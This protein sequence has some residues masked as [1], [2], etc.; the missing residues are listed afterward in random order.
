MNPQVAVKEKV[1]LPEQ[2]TVLMDGNEMAAMAGAHINYHVMG[3][4]PITPSTDI[5]ENL[6]AMKADGE[7]DIV[8]I[9]GD[10]EHGAAGSCYGAAAAGGRVFNATSSQGLL[11]ALEQ[12]P[13]QSG[14][15]FP[16][17]LNVVCRS[18]S[19]PLDIRGDHSDIMF[20]LNT[21]WIILLAKDQQMVYDMNI[22]A[23]RLGEHPDV[24]LPVIVGFDGFFT[25]HQKRRVKH[26]TD[27][28]VVQDFI[29]PCHTPYNILDTKHP[30]TIGAYMNDP[31]Y[32][33]NKKQQ[34][35][36]MEIAYRIA[37][38]IIEEY[39][40]LSGRHYP[41]VDTYRMEDAE[42]A[43]FILNSAFD[44]AKEAVDILRKEG[45]KVG[46]VTSYMIRP[47]PQNEIQ[48]TFRNAAAICVGDRQES[49]GGWGGNMTIEIKAALKDDPQNHS[50]V[51][52]RIYGLGGK[53]FF[54]G[55]AIQMLNEA[56]ET[57]KSKRVSSKMEYIGATPG[58]P[59]NLPK[60]VTLPLTAQDADPGIIRVEKDEK[61]GKM[62]V[63]GINPRELT[64]MPKR[65]APGHGACPGC[66]IF[67]ALNAFLR[68]ISGY[69]V[70]LFHTGCGMITTTP[71]PCTS[72][73][74]TYIHNLFQNGA[75][76]LAGTVEMYHERKR[77][78]EIPQDEEITFIAVTGDGGNDIGMGPTIGAA[79]R[80]HKMILLEYD[81]EGYMNTGHQLS[82]TT[83]FAHATS[84]SHVGPK[85]HGKQTHH[86]DTVQ[87]MS[88]CHIPYI[89]TAC[90]TNH[91]DLTRKAAKAQKYA[92]EEGFV[93]AKILSACPLNWRIR[94]QE[95]RQVLQAFID[96]CFF[97]LYEIE[98]GITTLNYDPEEKKKR[99]PVVEWLKLMG[100]TRHLT[101][102]Q[103][104][105]ELERVEAEVERRWRRIKAMHESPI[106]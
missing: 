104:K 35:L 16:M 91:I 92:T 2:V 101:Q 31:D 25:S 62:V 99:I 1:E 14:T 5:P 90:E 26:F 66:G 32:I 11:Y 20:A 44:I 33:N 100:K 37:P 50:L 68:G 12:L 94:D 75:A 71:Y 13:V 8:M 89:F 41:L 28:K 53:E 23:V 52:S 6:D 40:V 56:L 29:G 93:F 69:V 18:V 57:A 3:Y 106:L 63:R 59:A 47:F 4:Y 82:F 84:T 76:T 58:D 7:H 19:G 15:R 27:R 83:P 86:K 97:P 65:I 10:G 77:R 34:S 70:M 67:P 85:Q 22:I 72:H 45:K 51:F 61:T 49:F 88:A 48:E 17:V 43:L 79:L 80:N 64:R 78:G 96:S 46:V 24:R 60:P 103:F 38:Q 21:G 9:P 42:A 105:P 55:D 73:R 102:P 74:M 95:C 30:T 87:I 36:A 54:L 39:A 81:N 98:H